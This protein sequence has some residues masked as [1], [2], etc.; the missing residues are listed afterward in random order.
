MKSSIILCFLLTYTACAQSGHFHGN[1]V[2]ETGD[3]MAL[4]AEAEAETMENIPGS[5]L[6]CKSIMNKVKASM[7]DHESKEEIKKKLHN[8]CNKLHFVKGTC[9]K[10]VNKYLN[11]LADE[12]L[13]SDGARTA[14]VKIKLC[15]PKAL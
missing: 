14:C 9:K 2:L 5:C 3:D 1:G 12:L 6:I 4:E 13:T 11:K 8:V 15:K 10:V 7:S